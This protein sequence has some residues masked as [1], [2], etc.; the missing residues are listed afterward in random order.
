MKKIFLTLALCA[1]ISNTVFAGYDVKGTKYHFNSE[2]QMIEYE[3]DDGKKIEYGPCTMVEKIGNAIKAANN[4]EEELYGLMDMEL[5][6]I[7]PKIYEQ[8]LY[9]ED[10]DSYICYNR[11]ENITDYYDGNFNKI[12]QPLFI[13]PL[14]DTNYYMLTVSDDADYEQKYYYICDKAGNKLI[15]ESFKNIRSYRNCIICKNQENKIGVYDDNLNLVIPYGTYESVTYDD[16]RLRCKSSNTDEITYLSENFKPIAIDDEIKLLFGDYY[17][18]KHND[19]LYYIC[20]SE[21]SVLKDKGYF[22]IDNMEGRIKVRSSDKYPRLYGLLDENLNEIFEEK[23][24]RIAHY[25]TK[26]LTKLYLNGSIE[27]HDEDNKLL[28]TEEGPMFVTPING[29]AGRRI[30]DQYPDADIPGEHACIIIDDEGNALTPEYVKVNPNTQ[31]GNTLIVNSV[32]GYSDIVEGVLNSNLDVIIAPQYGNMYVKEENGIIYIENVWEGSNTKYYDLYGNKYDTKE[33]LFAGAEKGNGAGAWAK[34]SIEKAIAAGI[35]P[36]EIQS[37]YTR[38]ITR[39]EFCKLA[40]KTYMAKTDYTLDENTESPFT[41]IDN[42]YVTAAYNLKIVAG[43]GNNKFIPND[44]IT[45]QEAAVM[46]NN[47]ADLLG[48][49]ISSDATRFD[50]ESSFA[51]WAKSA[52]YSVTSIKSGNTYIMAG[53]GSGKFSPLMNYT[54]EQAIATLYR[55]YCC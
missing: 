25:N 7:T 6:E 51:D 11:E 30:Y 53:T 10:T 42:A 26:K 33:E 37:E 45:R 17:Y 54:R 8:I 46:L 19:G 13:K 39:Q 9:D 24:F 55:L 43:K 34:E 4:A 35:V 52:I 21:G 50:D 2:T 38:N 18:Q 3:N 41:D 27:T 15:N 36:D 31:P 47:L 20:N 23:Y 49:K 44:N 16:G 28:E 22:E 48:A 1:L 14:E 5:N 29:M 32:M 40:V 12:S